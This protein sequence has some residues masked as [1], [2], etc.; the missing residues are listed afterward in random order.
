MSDPAL[1]ALLEAGGVWLWDADLVNETTVYQ[2]GFWEQYGHDPANAVETFDFLQFVHRGDLRDI[3]KT[4]R[5]HLD[6]ETPIYEAE[7]R[8]R[9]AGGEWRW[10]A[11]RGRVT[12]RDSAGKPTR[13]VG[14]YSD[15]TEMKAAELE[16]MSA[17]ADLDAVFRSSRDGLAL[18]APDL[19][20]RRANNAAV[21]LVRRV[22]GVEMHEGE[23][24]RRV[25]AFTPD[26]PVLG[27]I[28]A[29]L[30]G[31]RDL[32]ERLIGGGAAGVWIEFSYSSVRQPDGEIL[33]A[34]VTIRDVTERVR[35]E[36]ARSRVLRLESLGLLTGGIAHD[37]NNL[38]GAIGGNIEL[39]Q[40]E[41]LPADTREGLSEAG[42]AVRRASEMVREL[43][44]FAGQQQPEFGTVDLRELTHEMVRYARRVPG[45]N[46]EIVEELGEA[47]PKTSAD[48][49]QLRQVVLNLLVNAIDATR[50]GGH[51]TVRLRLVHDL[52]AAGTDLLFEP[53]PADGYL[54]LEVEDDGYGMEEETRQRIFEPFFTTKANGHGLGL[55]SV[56]GSVRSHGGSLGVRS[57][58][59][60]GTTFTVVLPAS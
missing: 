2:D 4:W 13:M 8:L 35:N 11:S 16:R 37:F 46:A 31:R 55:A 24:V 28:L 25:P 22:S 40:M 54:V 26:R 57:A 18:I 51:I 5:A 29:A 52:R 49:T 15:I 59:G 41:N 1:R 38:L 21:E 42:E 47:L 27:D 33:G 36:Q 34:A 10:I 43:L 56:L 20:V 58:P 14:S 6:G 7:W 32:P 12:E 17:A 53:R 30:S 60:A 9:T 45:I 48:A 50:T 44:A 19:T 39:A 23:S 3:T